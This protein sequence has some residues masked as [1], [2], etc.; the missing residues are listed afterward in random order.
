[1]EYTDIKKKF[2]GYELSTFKKNSRFIEIL[3][4]N[5]GYEVDHDLYKK[6]IIGDVAPVTV[7]E[8]KAKNMFDSYIF[9]LLNR[10]NDLNVSV[11]RKFYNIYFYS[12]I[13]YETGV[14][15]QTLFYKPSSK[16]PI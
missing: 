6:I 5:Q 3:L 13:D 2:I 9:L 12:E 1:M 8:K 11:V 14:K 16:S 15:L 10:K 7:S 4:Y